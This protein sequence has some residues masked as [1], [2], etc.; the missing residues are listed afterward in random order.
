MPLTDEDFRKL[1]D[2]LAAQTKLA[3]ELAREK[4]QL[5]QAKLALNQQIQ[6]ITAD[7][8]ARIKDL[9]VIKAGADQIAAD[10]AVVDTQLRQTGADRDARVKELQ[11]A[12]NRLN[13]LQAIIDQ[14]KAD[15]ERLGA[16]RPRF[17][18]NA[19]TGQLAALL[20]K[21]HARIAEAEPG[22]AA[23]T[24]HSLD[25]ELRG[26]VDLTNQDTHLVVPRAGE[27]VDAGTLSV[28]RMSFTTVPA[29]PKNDG[30]GT[31]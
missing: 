19:I 3:G 29:P 12:A 17:T 25:I 9:N 30:G 14:Q 2:Q 20:E 7:R 1:K 27:V 4:E 18:I 13:G 21:S 5:A 6:E 11:D 16:D 26:F 8:D 10:K 24:L 23:A 31:Q 22:T 15:I 28:M